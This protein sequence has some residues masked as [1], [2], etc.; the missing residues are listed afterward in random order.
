MA[1]AVKTGKDK[2]GFKRKPEERNI[3]VVTR[4]LVPEDDNVEET[5]KPGVKPIENPLDQLQRNAQKIAQY[6]QD[7]DTIS[8]ILPDMVH[9]QRIM[10]ASILS[11]RDLNDT[12]LGLTADDSQYSAELI[13]LLL[14]P[15]KEY[16][17][18]DYKIDDKLPKWVNK[19]LNTEGAYPILVLPEN[20]IDDLIGSTDI[21]P[22]NESYYDEVIKDSTKRLGIL[23]KAGTSL[24]GVGNEHF[25]PTEDDQIYSGT[26]RALPGLRI[27]DNPNVLK[28]AVLREKLRK[29]KIN[30]AYGLQRKSRA[31]LEARD[32]FS[33]K[34]IQKAYKKNLDPAHTK[35]TIRVVRTQ[36]QM[37]RKSSGH[38][39]II[40][41][42][43]ESV[44]PIYRQGRPEEHIGYYLFLD[45]ATGEP[46]S[47]ATD[48][49]YFGEIRNHYSTML[50]TAR[51]EMDE[52]SA[53]LEQVRSALGIDTDKEG[54][55]SISAEDLRGNYRTILEGSLLDALTNG[56]YD[57]DISLTM[58]DEVMSLVLWR[59]MKKRETQILFIPAEL[60]SYIAFEY[61]NRGFGQSM[62][63]RTR[64]LSSARVSLF[65][66]TAMGKIQNARP[67]RRVNITIDGRDEDAMKTFEDYKSMI[68]NQDFIGSCIGNL[69]PM[70]GIDVIGR[71]AYEFGLSVS[72]NGAGG[73]ALP[74]DVIDFEDI[75]T[76]IPTDEEDFDKKLKNMVLLAQGAQPE[77]FDPDTNPDFASSLVNNNLLLTREVIQ[78]QNQLLPALDKLVR[79][80][81][82]NSSIIFNEIVDTI[83]TNKKLLTS[84]QKKIAPDELAIDFIN[85]ITT[86]LP[87]P[88]N[89]R[90]E[91][92]KT[93]VDDMSDFLDTALDAFLTEDQFPDTAPEDLKNQMMLIKGIMKAKFLRDYMAREGIA[94]ELFR[95]MELEGK[96]KPAFSILDTQKQ[97]IETLGKAVGE[98]LK[99]YQDNSDNS[100]DMGY[101]EEEE[102][103][104]DQTGDE[105][106]L[107]A[108]DDIADGDLESTELD[109]L[110]ESS[111]KDGDLEDDD[112]PSEDGEEDE[113]PPDVAEDEDDLD[114]TAEKNRK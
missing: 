87:T 53:T 57:Q 107:D 41:P 49:D 91:A 32:S 102:N 38:P 79:T 52:T 1:R 6:R 69:D 88:S 106:D 108:S 96:N 75:K 4:K 42:S 72:Q 100:G 66:A 105:D 7:N 109:D 3:D 48:R 54:G 104:G 29:A 30:S 81:S 90:L 13:P 114:D 103:G 101:N 64:L 78:R 5:I 11:P 20:V 92:W 17:K 89:D 22:G 68:L 71:S 73:S 18:S 82:M 58:R 10:V 83:T 46:I 39:I 16:F 23:G 112:A 50:E 2:I 111:E 24:G 12:D 62:L 93:A 94:P 55:G 33:L 98:F 15:I 84:E 110:D 77:L 59:Q 80:F 85:S 27:T 67:R 19:A 36:I 63:T 31:G 60:M 99:E 113:T 56:Y 26:G 76:D 43:S 9:S 97:L 28:K 45:S 47:S 61:D 86:F 14:K 8:Q 21:S 40:E 51:G 70:T 35:E 74:E 65:F 95:V 44:T 34:E 25:D 37:E